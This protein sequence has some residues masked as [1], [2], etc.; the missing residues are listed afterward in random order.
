MALLDK[1][2][3]NGSTLN[4]LKGTQP[5]AA[6]KDAATL[7]VNDSFSKGKYQSYILDTDRATDLTGNS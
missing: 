2:E 3:T 5:E 4:P 6:L 1:F 7:P